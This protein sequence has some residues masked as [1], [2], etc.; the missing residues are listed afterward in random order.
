MN[1]NKFKIWIVFFCFISLNLFSSSIIPVNSQNDISFLELVA[2]ENMD[3]WPQSMIFL[4][5]DSLDECFSDVSINSG[6][7]IVFKAWVFDGQEYWQ[8]IYLSPRKQS[9]NQVREILEVAKV[10][11][12]SPLG[13]QNEEK[14]GRA[15]DALPVEWWRIMAGWRPSLGSSR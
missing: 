15:S 8:G 14:K 5:H 1:C 13:T 12:P 6:G 7:D 11:D 9:Y 4:S 3:T 2:Y 10:G